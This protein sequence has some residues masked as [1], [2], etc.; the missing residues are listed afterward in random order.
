MVKVEFLGPLGK[1]PIEVD[2]ENLQEL[3][4]IF[5]EDKELQEW[6]EIFL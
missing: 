3:R 2:I 1:E 4:E 5:K 6:L